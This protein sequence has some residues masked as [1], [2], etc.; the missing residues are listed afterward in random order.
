MKY[1]SR[2]SLVLLMCVSGSIQAGELVGHL[3]W[4]NPQILAF[5]VTGVIDELSAQA[6]AQLK[7]GQALA[8]LDQQPFKIAISRYQASVEAIEP[9]IGDALREY[10]HAQELY[11]QTVLSEVELQLKQAQLARLQAQQKMAQQDVAMARWQQQRSVLRAPSDGVLLASRLLPGM[12]ISEENQAQAFALFADT[13]VMALR[14]DLS[15]E[16]RSQFSLGQKLKVKID[17]QGLNAQISSITFIES[18]PV[19][20]EMVL[21]FPQQPGQHFYAGQTATVVY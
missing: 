10:Q 17:K 6:G 7:Q 20:Y 14:V 2:I 8:K 3:E 15:V 19:T 1:P 18:E 13:S 21:Q 12:V 16:Q 11:E 4:A 5:P 9:L